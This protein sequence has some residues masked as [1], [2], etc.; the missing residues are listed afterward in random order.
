MSSNGSFCS[1]SEPF[2]N[3]VQ[4]VMLLIETNMIQSNYMMCVYIRDG[5]LGCKHTSYNTIQ[6]ARG[7]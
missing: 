5:D 6:Q 4:S 3:A 7:A 1:K 2:Q